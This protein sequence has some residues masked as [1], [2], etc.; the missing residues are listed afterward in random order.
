MNRQTDMDYYQAL[1]VSKSASADEIRKAY[2]KLA[3]ENH[4]DVKPDDAA[5]AQKFKEVQEAYDVLKDSEKRAKYDQF[6]H[7]AYTQAGGRG[8]G[9]STGPGGQQ[10]D[11]GDIFGD[12]FGG[13][14]GGRGHGGFGGFGGGGGRRAQPRAQKGQDA[15][16]EIQIPF[17][18]AALGGTYE[19]TLQKGGQTER[20]DVKIPA[21]VSHGSVIKLGGQGHPGAGGGPAGDLLVKIQVSSHPYFRREGN[22]LLVDIP[23]TP[24]EAVLGA[25]IDVPTISEGQV[26][27][28]MP[29]GTSSGTRLRLPEMG[30]R[31]QRT[32]K[33]G[34]QFAVIKIV[35]PGDTSPEAQALYQQLADL[36]EASPR[37]GLW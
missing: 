34:D 20:L 9:W 1:G 36:S 29:P 19:L 31:D 27:M 3:R 17:T 2:K 4:P 21:G 24:A 32:A 15:K 7:A 28:K 11:L 37:D 8:G 16:T 30:V 18:T 35:V 26:V 5:A 22:N 25:K 6:G 12:I 23:V 10:I 13:G 33:K 14:K